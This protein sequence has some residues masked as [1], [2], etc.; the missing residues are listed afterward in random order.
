MAGL[1]ACLWPC[2]PA[3]HVDPQ[4]HT[5]PPPLYPIQHAAGYLPLVWAG[6]LAYYLDNAFEEAGLILPVSA[7][8][9]MQLA[10]V[11]E[12]LSTRY[13]LPAFPVPGGQCLVPTHPPTHLPTCL[14]CR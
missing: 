10:S 4:C 14:L 8:A 7:P 1:P 12:Q 3:C 5:L 6:T 11:C 13:S 9:R 2:L